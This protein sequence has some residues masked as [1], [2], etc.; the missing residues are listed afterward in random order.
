MKCSY[1]KIGTSLLIAILLLIGI[2]VS[3][4]DQVFD[5]Y[6][7]TSELV[8]I[9]GND[10]GIW[11]AGNITANITKELINIAMDK[12]GYIFIMYPVK[13][14]T[15]AIYYKGQFHK[16][17]ESRVRQGE[18]LATTLSAARTNHLG[19]IGLESTTR[20]GFQFKAAANSA[21]VYDNI[22]NELQLII[23][24]PLAPQVKYQVMAAMT[25]PIG[26]NATS[27]ASISTPTNATAVT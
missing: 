19:D 17:L 14:A 5:R 2:A 24:R 4:D 23:Y 25:P 26:W 22:T 9:I 27:S 1:F 12:S 18:Y 16:A 13:G 3:N 10:T 20:D 11:P 6:L 21:I 15:M 8:S 7:E